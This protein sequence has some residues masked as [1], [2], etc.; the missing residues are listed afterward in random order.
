M[1]SNY[2]SLTV[3]KEI[4]IPGHVRRLRTV[5]G[6]SSTEILVN[7]SSLFKKFQH[8]SIYS[9]KTICANFI[10]TKNKIVLCD[11]LSY[12]IFIF[13]WVKPSWYV[14]SP[15]HDSNEERDEL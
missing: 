7:C 12:F 8:P 13:N 2:H 4:E 10:R 5:G 3:H 15:A 11:A 6:G 14:V 1:H 9:E